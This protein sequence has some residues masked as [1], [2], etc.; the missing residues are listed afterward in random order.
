MPGCKKVRIRRK[1][2]AKGALPQLPDHDRFR[3]MFIQPDGKPLDICY[4]FDH[5]GEAETFAKQVYKADHSL[6]PK[7]IAID[8]CGLGG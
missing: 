8:D 7:I 3:V 2:L 6:Q 1:G 5:R 4:T